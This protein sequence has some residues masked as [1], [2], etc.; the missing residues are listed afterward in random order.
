MYSISTET[1]S[2]LA[3]Q[4]PRPQGYK[5]LIAVAK[6]N[7]KKGSIYLPDKYV[8]LENTASILGVVMDM[9]RE[10]YSD[11]AKFPNGPYCQKGEWVMFKTY[12]GTR[13]KVGEQEFRFINDDQVEAV[14]PDPSVIDRV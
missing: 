7:E 9:G 11:P 13:F 1:I 10:A 14:V 3:P 2:A 5:V 4:L 8:D 12:A 6:I